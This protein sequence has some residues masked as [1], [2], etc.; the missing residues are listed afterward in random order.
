VLLLVDE[1]DRPVQLLTTQQLRRFLQSRLDADE[2]SRAGRTDLAA[3]VRGVRWRP[4]GCAFDG[5]WWYY[6]LARVLHVEDYRT[7]ISFGRAWFL[8]VDFAQPI[9]DIDITER[10]WRKPGEYI[11]PWPTHK[12]GL[13]A[14]DGLR[15]LFDLC[16]YPE[17]I[18]RAPHGNPCAYLEMGRCDAPCNGSVPLATYNER[19]RAAWAFAT[20]N[21][22][23]W[24]RDADIRMRAAAAEQRFEQA[25]QIKRQLA[26][27]QTW[28][29]QWAAR[30]RLVRGTTLLLG[31]RATRRRAWKL[32]L[33]RDGDLRD[34]PIVPARNA[35]NDIAAW[36]ES[37]RCGTASDL[38]DIVRMEQTWLVC[39]LL[40]HRE[41]DAALVVPLSETNADSTTELQS[42]VSELLKLKEQEASATS[43]K[44]K[45]SRIANEG[46]NGETS[47]PD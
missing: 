29:Q 41:R 17:Q 39:H 44:R 15:D 28:Q 12:A 4:V 32:Y 11:G 37:E 1:S 35:A 30:T 22:D 3:V 40:V 26:F 2:Q 7:R 8:H 16:R 6:Q 19:C 42:R 20:G 31:L 9:P 21:V 14:L 18:R 46:E 34:G 45:R 25:A 36:G 24:Q 38:P 27:A 43:G 5:R 33:F 13:Q 47:Q 10:V 23:A